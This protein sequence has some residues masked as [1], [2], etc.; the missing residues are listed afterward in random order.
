MQNTSSRKLM[1]IIAIGLM[2][3]LVFISTKFLSIDI[4]VGVSGKT[5]VHLGNTMCLLAGL[6][7]GGVAGGLS[8]GMGSMI[9]DLLDPLWISGAPITFLMKFAMGMSCG[10][11]A[12]RG[13]KQG[14]DHKT[15]IVAAVTGQALYIVLYLSKS[16]VSSLLVGNGLEAA[17][18]A[19]VPK[20]I[21]SLINAVIAVAIAVPLSFV[22]RKAL[23]RAGLFSSF[24]PK[25]SE[26]R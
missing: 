23:C 17:L 14:G 7:F 13:G 25:K 9:V 6:L 24:F 15:N 26:A 22:I 5:H 16:L 8:S 11:I 20:G 12:H 1:K 2:A 3:A 4:P 18:A 10:L 19:L 21:S